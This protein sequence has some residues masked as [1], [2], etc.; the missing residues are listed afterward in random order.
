M[1]G[2]GLMLDLL[3]TNA[4]V[5]TMSDG[6]PFGLVKQGA[7]G[8]LNGK[9]AWI[10]AAT[11]APPAAIVR[12]VGGKVVTPGLVD[13]HTHIV[14]GEEGL[15]DFEVLSLGGHRWDLEPKG[16]GVGHLV[17]R[18]RLLTEEAL[19]A[20]SRARMSRL[21]ANGVTTVESKSGAGL[22]LDTELRLMRISRQLGRDLPV[23]V[24]STYLGAHGLAPEYAGRRDDYVAFM[25]EQVLPEAVRQDV[26]DQVDG[27]CDKVGFSH[28]QMDRLFDCARAFGLG[29]KLHADQYT[30]FGA[31]AVVAH[32]H[33]LSADHLEYASLS[34]VQAMAEAG[35]VATLLPGAHFILHETRKPPVDTFRELGVPMALATNS[36]P[37]SSPTVSPAAQMH[38]GCYL[39]RLTAEEALRGFTVNA[40]RALG[41][42][43]KAGVIAVGRAADL[44]LWDT[45]DPRGIAYAIGGAACVGVI[46]DGVIVHDAPAPDFARL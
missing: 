20:A 1:A 46:K 11:Q 27:F 40:A 32:H 21:I 33:G 28:A 25:C 34:T 2:G 38:L 18:T 6:A 42:A 13:P 41:L 39:F 8:I 44:A 35:T 10:G 3:L 37:V 15:I 19:Y 5:A 36:N 9:V 24:V 17:R 29:V 22:D 31:G 43:D 26:V 4:C 12:D 7:V 23:T 16:G 14:Y 30:D 45:D